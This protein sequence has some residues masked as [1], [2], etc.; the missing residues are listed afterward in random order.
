MFCSGSLKGLSFGG[1]SFD[2]NN[3]VDYQCVMQRGEQTVLLEVMHY[4]KPKLS[5][6]PPKENR[7]ANI[8]LPDGSK[9]QA[10]SVHD[11][12]KSKRKTPRPA[13]DRITKEQNLVGALGR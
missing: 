9:T 13:G 3:K 7:T 5:L 2:R 1:I 12:M 10:V 8:T 11:L 4:K 6:G